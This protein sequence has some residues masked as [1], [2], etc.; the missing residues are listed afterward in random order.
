VS[1]VVQDL[2]YKLQKRFRRLQSAGLSDL[3][4]ELVRF[5]SF[6][7]DEPTLM[8]LANELVNKH[9]DIPPYVEKI[10]SGNQVVGTT[11]SEHAAIGYH[12]LR[13][14]SKTEPRKMEFMSFAGLQGGVE[15]SLDK[16]RAMYLEPFYEY[17]DEQLEDKNLVLSELVRF[18]HLA[19]WFRRK[20]LWERYENSKTGERTLAYCI[21][22]FLYEQG[23]N[24]QIEP[25]S[26]SGEADMVGMQHSSD[27]LIADVK[28]F[29][30]DSSRGSA[31]IKRGFHQVY[32]YL[33][34]FNKP[35]GYLVVFLVT[36]KR[37]EIQLESPGETLVPAITIHHKTIFMIQVDIFPHE[38]PAS[39]R[40]V[41]ECE[42]ISADELAGE[43]QATE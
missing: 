2:R 29:D 40:P 18:K 23:V 12:V 30:P 6:F 5:W 3:T 1:R 43:A 41:A 24:F 42:T 9:P 38:E 33:E 10:P 4:H 26:A 17:V 37:L 25:A 36:P 19:E 39:R 7:D 20:D 34:D 32:R 16:F 13:T 31:Y 22:E 15:R 28:I 8:A 21:Y 11:E 27:P 35:V 14:V